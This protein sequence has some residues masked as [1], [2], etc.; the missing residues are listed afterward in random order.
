MSLSDLQKSNLSKDIETVLFTK[1]KLTTILYEHTEKF[2]LNHYDQIPGSDHPTKVIN[3]I[4]ELDNRNLIDYFVNIV[5]QKYPIVGWHYQVFRL[6]LLLQ[7]VNKI[8]PK[9][10]NYIFYDKKINIDCFEPYLLKLIEKDYKD[11]LSDF[12]TIPNDLKPFDSYIRF[13]DFV[14]EYIIKILTIPEIDSD[15]K[16]RLRQWLKDNFSDIVLLSENQNITILQSYLLIIILPMI[17]QVN[18]NK[19]FNIH[20]EF[21]ENFPYTSS[22]TIELNKE[23]R[24]LEKEIPN[25]ICKFIKIVENEDKYLRSK[26]YYNQQS[27]TLRIE[28]FLPISF[29]TKDFE[30]KIP[31][32]WKKDETAIC[33]QYS[34]IL[35]SLDR[36]FNTKWQSK[37]I[38]KWKKITK[39]TIEQIL[40]LNQQDINKLLSNKKRIKQFKNI[41][42]QKII[43][44][45]PCSLPT[46]SEQKEILF[47]SICET[48]IP[49]CLWIKDQKHLEPQC[50]ANQLN[51]L[52]KNECLQD[53]NELY[54][55]IFEMRKKDL[56]D[57]NCEKCLG[58]HLRVLCDNTDRLP[59]SFLKDH[60]L[61]FELIFF[62]KNSTKNKKRQ[63]LIIN[64]K[65]TQEKIIIGPFFMVMETSIMLLLPIFRRLLLGEN[66]KK[67]SNLYQKNWKNQQNT[68]KLRNAGYKFKN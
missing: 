32:I 42:E 59:T 53:I 20:A 56:A 30:F 13:K 2:G 23:H 45:I 60:P 1:D 22:K 6:A 29:F 33:E 64:L 11:I 47:K 41:L 67:F 31:D 58:Y 25:I 27:Y 49:L 68:S 16:E 7:E 10:I 44:K 36:L 66:S 62:D 8:D 61:G 26:V 55:K 63:C 46:D 65:I 5:S 38:D 4:R 9:F 34:V 35:R 21:I 14:N 3:L 50:I 48:G 24:Y 28:L 19:T 18:N 12:T 57:L 39:T 40:N 51:C 43:L 52:I 54:K 37:C 15:L 17:G